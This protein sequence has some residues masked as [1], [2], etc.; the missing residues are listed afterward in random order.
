MGADAVVNSSYGDKAKNGDIRC[1]ATDV[2][3]C[4]GGLEMISWELNVSW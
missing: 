4:D 1:T 2:S 3:Y